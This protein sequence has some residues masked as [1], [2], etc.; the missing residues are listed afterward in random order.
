MHYH[1]TVDPH[2]FFQYLELRKN[3]IPIEYI[4]G[5]V[6]FYS[7]EFLINEGVLIPRPETEILIDVASRAIED[8][9]CTRIAEI[10]T[11]SGI[12]SV[13]LALKHPNATFTA[14]DINE[15]AIELAKR[16]SRKFGVEERISFVHA[17]YLD[18]LDDESFD[19]LVSNPP[20]IANDCKLETQLY[21]EPHN[22]LF[23]GERG[24][25]IILKI[26]DLTRERHI[27][28]LCIEMGYDQKSAV[29]EYFADLSVE[30]LA[31][32]QDLAGLDRGF[33]AAI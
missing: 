28:Y 22:A 5:K 19:L 32:Y 2:T 17:S 31:F 10:G 33:F 8:Y 6:S 23:G 30:T 25:E 24:D 9:G 13:M 27:P 14:T 18:T 7:E 21:H 11:G 15:Q 3:H 12:I 4:L 20:Y 1:D 29:S 16:N 26:I